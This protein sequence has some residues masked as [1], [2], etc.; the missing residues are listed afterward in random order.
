MAISQIIYPIFSLL[1]MA[2]ISLQLSSTFVFD[3]ESSSADPSPAGSNRYPPPIPDHLSLETL[4][5]LGSPNSNFDTRHSSSLGSGP[6]G[7]RMG[8]FSAVATI[9][10]IP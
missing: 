3:P 5:A 4:C 7:R 1:L 8:Q 2:P 6:W 9:G 10:P